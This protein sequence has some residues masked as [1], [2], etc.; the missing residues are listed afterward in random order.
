MK[1]FIN[2]LIRPSVAPK[3][4]DWLVK[5]FAK[6]GVQVHS[7]ECNPPVVRVFA[8]VHELF[9]LIAANRYWIVDAH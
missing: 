6:F 7:V 1:L 2:L 3:H 4:P 5:R 9:E 8:T